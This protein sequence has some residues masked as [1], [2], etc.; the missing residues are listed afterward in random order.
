VSGPGC[1]TEFGASKKNLFKLF[2]PMIADTI[3]ILLFIFDVLFSSYNT[4]A[5]DRTSIK[6]PIGKILIWDA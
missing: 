2:S 3:K 4:N 6:F 5:S 1:V